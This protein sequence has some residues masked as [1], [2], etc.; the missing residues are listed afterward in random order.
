MMK[1]LPSCLYI[2]LNLPEGL[3]HC[4]SC[5]ASS[6]GSRTQTQESLSP[7]SSRVPVSNDLVWEREKPLIPAESLNGECAGQQEQHTPKRT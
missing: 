1:V 5:T 2:Y 3:N 4:P 6:H 7:E